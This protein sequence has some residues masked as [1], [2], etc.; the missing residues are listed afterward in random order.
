[1]NLWVAADSLATTE[2]SRMLAIGNPDDPASHFAEMCKPGSGW[3]VMHISA[4]DSPNFTGEEVPDRVRGMLTSKDWVEDKRRIWG[5]Q[6]PLWQSKVLGQFPDV[7]DDT[8]I[9][10]GWVRAAID[11]WEETEDGDSVELGCDIARFGSNAT[12]IIC[13]RGKR[14]H[15]HTVLH[16]RDLMY[17]CGAIVQAIRETGAT[18]C[19][20]DDAGLGGGVTDRL[21]EL[22]ADNLF[23]HHNVD[24]IPVNVGFAP[25]DR[26]S[27]ESDER[28]ES[29]RFRNLRA[30]LF[31]NLRE[32]FERGEIAIP[33]DNDL[34]GQLTNIKYGMTSRGQIEIER[35]EKMAE[36]GVPSPDHADALMLACAP[37]QP[38]WKRAWEGWAA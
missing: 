26:H 14:C 36:R 38:R 27:R 25:S 32:L 16:Q 33:E 31:W 22:V 23:G 35:K 10:P 4:F 8:L 15:V 28:G 3:Y 1:M 12:V 37:L 11:R 19:K 20:L 24:I 29:E 30:E 2:G 7:G 34:A 18:V 6:S 13:K 5:E 21:K 17:V 9:P